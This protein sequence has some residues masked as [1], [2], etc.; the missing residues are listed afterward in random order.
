MCHIKGNVCV[1]VTSDVTTVSRS[2]L[3]GSQRQFQKMQL[4]I[5]F[6]FD[7][8]WQVLGMINNYQRDAGSEDDRDSGNISLIASLSEGDQVWVEWRGMPVKL[9]SETMCEM[10]RMFLS[11]CRLRR[12]ILV[13]QPL[14]PH[15]VHR[16]HDSSTPY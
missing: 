8:G 1:H 10:T 2:R 9:L 6:F 14:P 3:S 16:V 15:L 5:N 7:S 11:C 4:L 13:Q 12:L